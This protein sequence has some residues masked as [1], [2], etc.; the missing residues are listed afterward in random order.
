MYKFLW[1]TTCIVISIL[2]NHCGYHIDNWE[3]WVGCGCVW[4][5]FVVGA[6]MG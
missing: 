6:V 1:L 5:A 2:M 4:L 3:W